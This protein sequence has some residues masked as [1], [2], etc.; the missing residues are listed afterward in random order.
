MKKLLALLVLTCL[1]LSTH[2]VSNKNI[3]IV[4]N[5]TGLG[6]DRLGQDP[7]INVE[8]EQMIG[9]NEDEVHTINNK[10]LSNNSFFQPEILKH[11]LESGWMNYSFKVTPNYINID[12]QK[13]YELQK[14]NNVDVESAFMYISINRLSGISKTSATYWYKVN[15]PLDDTFTQYR[16]D[17]SASGLCAKGLNKF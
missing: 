5:L 12:F 10:F 11:G 6:T 13:S 15:S 4:C 7:Y 14:I 2:D 3:T 8:I 1:P 16:S 17:Y 9:F